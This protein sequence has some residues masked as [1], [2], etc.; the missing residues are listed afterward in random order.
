M[1]AGRLPL[2]ITEGSFSAVDNFSIMCS[3]PILAINVWVLVT[4]WPGGFLFHFDDR[5]IFRQSTILWS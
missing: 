5:R 4:T 3:Q 1:G 2:R